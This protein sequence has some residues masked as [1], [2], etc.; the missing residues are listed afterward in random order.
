MSNEP[1]AD[2]DL[3]KL[4]IGFSM[5]ITGVEASIND[6]LRA[7]VAGVRD[8]DRVTQHMVMMDS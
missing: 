1:Q 2:R 3:F 8:L 7:S 5:L 4:I 6:L